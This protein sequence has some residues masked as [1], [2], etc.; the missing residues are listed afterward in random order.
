M[1]ENPTLSPLSSIAVAPC[2]LNETRVF[3]L[4]CNVFSPGEIKYLKWELFSAHHRDISRPPVLGNSNHP[5]ISNRV[6]STKYVSLIGNGEFHKL[7]KSSLVTL[8]YVT[9]Q[10]TTVQS[11][12]S[13]MLPQPL[14][15]V[16]KLR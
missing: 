8:R 11:N 12:D 5:F 14:T 3:P 9:V 13:H 7:I 1:R 2:A 15:A 4:S 6:L 10:Y 16:E